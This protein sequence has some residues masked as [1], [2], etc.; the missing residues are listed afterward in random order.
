MVTGS[1]LSQ[2][3][4]PLKIHK[5]ELPSFHFAKLP[6]IQIMFHSSEKYQKRH[7][8]VHYGVWK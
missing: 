8:K 6:L 3:I 4:N 5:I 2:I 7:Q 1:R